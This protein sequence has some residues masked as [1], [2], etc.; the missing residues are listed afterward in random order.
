MIIP[1]GYISRS[2]ISELGAM[3]NFNTFDTQWQIS[4]P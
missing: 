3:P 1:L 4:V 2:E